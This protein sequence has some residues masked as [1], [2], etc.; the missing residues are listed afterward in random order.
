MSL[1]HISVSFPV[2]MMK[3]HLLAFL[4]L[5][6]YVMQKIYPI[7]IAIPDRFELQSQLLWYAFCTIFLF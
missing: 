2:Q 6:F 5:S 7:I 4:S 1:F 3:I